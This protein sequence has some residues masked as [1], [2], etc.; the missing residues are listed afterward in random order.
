M[1]HDLY[2]IFEKKAAIIVNK[3][4]S[5]HCASAKLIGCQA[6]LIGT[7]PCS[8]DILRARMEGVVTPEKLNPTLAKTLHEVLDK[9]EKLRCTAAP[10]AMVIDSLK[11]AAVQQ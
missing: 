4:P 6:P 10:L 11:Q 3:V 8:C 5:E 1:I 9:I 2:A 7:I